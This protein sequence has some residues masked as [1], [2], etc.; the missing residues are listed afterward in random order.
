M[1]KSRHVEQLGISNLVFV[2]FDNIRSSKNSEMENNSKNTKHFEDRNYIYCKCKDTIIKKQVNT[3]FY[4]VFL[5]LT[6]YP[7]FEQSLRVHFIS[8]CICK[9][10]QKFV[11]LN[12]K[13]AKM[14]CLYT[15]KLRMQTADFGN[16]EMANPWLFSAVFM[17][18]ENA[19]RNWVG[20]TLNAEW[21]RKRS[22]QVCIQ[23]LA[24]IQQSRRKKSG[25]SEYSVLQRAKG[26]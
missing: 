14:F 4:L 13:C 26:D 24:I 15:H 7:T 19:P 1:S 16:F 2:S 6:G 18:C 9:R 22:T 3:P 20:L 17:Y 21:Q 12:L 25:S 5:S 11:L 8:L 23:S 10:N